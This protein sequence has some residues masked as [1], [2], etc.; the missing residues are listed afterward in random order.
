[1]KTR[2]KMCEYCLSLYLMRKYKHKKFM[3]ENE[4]LMTKLP[5]EKEVI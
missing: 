1:M 5:K 2:N 3:I 4:K